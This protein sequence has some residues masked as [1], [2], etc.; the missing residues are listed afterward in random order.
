MFARKCQT[1]GSQEDLRHTNTEYHKGPPADP[2]HNECTNSVEDDSY[3]DP[4]ALQTKLI[5]GVVAKFA[6]KSRTIAGSESVRHGQRILRRL[7]C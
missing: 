1:P 5:L 3:C 2:V 6:V 4:A 7:T